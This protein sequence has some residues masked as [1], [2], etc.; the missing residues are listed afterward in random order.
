[1]YLFKYQDKLIMAGME[2]IHLQEWHDKLLSSSFLKQF[3]TKKRYII[4]EG[5]GLI[6]QFTL[7]SNCIITGTYRC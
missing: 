6:K 2:D 1:M 3:T 5:K 4:K 7:I